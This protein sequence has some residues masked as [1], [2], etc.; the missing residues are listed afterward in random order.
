MEEYVDK[1]VWWWVSHIP[2]GSQY[3][4]MWH[5]ENDDGTPEKILI[6]AFRL[7]HGRLGKDAPIGLCHKDL[8]RETI[9]RY[10]KTEYFKPRQK[11]ADQG[12]GQAYAPGAG[13][14]LT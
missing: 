6:D 8:M 12:T 11:W 14:R 13:P 5:R 10:S 2:R 3:D 4:Y 9:I 7:M 1:W